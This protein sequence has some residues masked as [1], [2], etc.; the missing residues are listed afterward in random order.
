M[1]PRLSLR[2]VSTND[3]QGQGNKMASSMMDSILA[4]VTPDMKQAIASRLGESAQAVQSGLS[5]TTAATLG[6]LAAKAGDSGFLSQIMNLAATRQ[7]PERARQSHDDGLR[8]AERRDLRSWWTSFCR[9]SSAR[10]RV[11]SRAPSRNTPASALPRSP[12]CSRWP[13]SWC[14]PSSDAP[15]RAA[16]SRQDRSAACSRR[17]PRACRATSPSGLVSNPGG[18][19]ARRRWRRHGRSGCRPGPLTL[20]RAARD[21]RRADHYVAGVS[22]HE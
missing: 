1:Q 7:H 3:H 9:W 13:H 5:A 12:A 10:S 6:A 17:K 14:W 15:R 2:P 4:L 20:A 22:F 18:G 8:H 21:S 11:R 16:P 19:V